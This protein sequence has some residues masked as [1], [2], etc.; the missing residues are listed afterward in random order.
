[1]PDTNRRRLA[2]ALVPLLLLGAT[3]CGG[4]PGEFADRDPLPSCG[5]VEHGAGRIVLPAKVEACMQ[6]ARGSRRGGELAL[7]YHSQ[8]GDPI[9]AYFRYEPGQTALLVW[10]D[11]SDDRFGSGAD[12]IRYRCRTVDEIAT[13]SDG[14]CSSKRF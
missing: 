13:W 1:V 2:P 9:R 5:Q 3:A 4:P 10:Q 8:E 7:T 12:W 11:V 14:D 6:R